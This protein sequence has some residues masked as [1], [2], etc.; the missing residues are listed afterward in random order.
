[1]CKPL[2]CAT[3]NRNKESMLYMSTGY[4]SFGAIVLYGDVRSV[5]WIAVA[6]YGVAW[7]VKQWTRW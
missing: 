3:R 6:Q 7:T 5:V 2:V 1:M 4:E